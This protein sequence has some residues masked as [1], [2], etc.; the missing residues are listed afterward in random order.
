MRAGLASLATAVALL[1]PLTGA[2]A[3]E[4]GL[5]NPGESTTESVRARYGAPSKAIPQKEAG[6]D[7]LRWVYEGSQA[8]PGMR[9]MTVDFGLMTPA[10]YRRELVRSLTLEPQRGIFNRQLVLSGWGQPTG[11]GQHADAPAFLYEEGLFVYFESDGWVVRSMLFTPRQRIP[12]T[13][14]PPPR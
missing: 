10:G 1:G 6:H 9:R 11:I 8:P 12:E 13:S 7:T 4:W 3:L 2:P 5:I 14:A